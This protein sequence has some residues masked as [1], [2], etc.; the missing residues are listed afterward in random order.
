MRT[1][2]PL[3]SIF[4]SLAF[5][6]RLHWP[7]VYRMKEPRQFAKS[8]A[9]T[10]LRQWHLI[11]SLFRNAVCLGLLLI[12]LRWAKIACNW[13]KFFSYCNFVSGIFVSYIIHFSLSLSVA[14][15]LKKVIDDPPS[16]KSMMFPLVSI[17]VHPCLVLSF[18]S[19]V[20]RSTNFPFCAPSTHL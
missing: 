14:A 3:P 11:L 9:F 8:L 1:G 10:S 2:S 18:T 15:N 4:R 5:F 6:A 20:Y 13:L 7:R 17:A 16:S 19:S 12:I